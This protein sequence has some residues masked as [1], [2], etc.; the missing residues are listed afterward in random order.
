MRNFQ[1]LS[2]SEI[3]S[4]ENENKE[5]EDFNSRIMTTRAGREEKGWLQV[6]NLKDP[7]E[8]QQFT[9]QTLKFEIRSALKLTACLLNPDFDQIDQER[10]VILD[11][12]DFRIENKQPEHYKA[13]KPR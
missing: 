1:N 5:N 13:L 10:K 11:L 7:N 2:F 12:D 6:E 8:F 3:E 4:S 9:P